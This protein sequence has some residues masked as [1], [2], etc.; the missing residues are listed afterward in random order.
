MSAELRPVPAVVPLTF[1][2]VQCERVSECPSKDFDAALALCGV[3]PP[4]QVWTVCDPCW[5]ALGF[6]IDK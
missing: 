5:L 4:D 3:L 6:P 2:C 1:R